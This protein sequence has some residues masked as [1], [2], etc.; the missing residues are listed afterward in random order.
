MDPTQPQVMTPAPVQPLGT[1]SNAMNQPDP[2]KM[3]MQSTSVAMPMPQPGNM[4]YNPQTPLA[5]P[6]QTAERQKAMEAQGQAMGR[7]QSPLQM[8]PEQQAMPGKPEPVQQVGRNGNTLWPEGMPGQGIAPLAGLAQARPANP[9]IQGSD[10][11]SPQHGGMN[12]GELGGSW[13]S[14]FSNKT[15]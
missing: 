1:T 8:T 13:D 4:Q 6:A 3:G 9:F 5:N 2:T 10:R 12:A 14:R 15:S 11:F 7:P